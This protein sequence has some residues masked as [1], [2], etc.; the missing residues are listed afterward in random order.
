[1]DRISRVVIENIEPQVDQGRFLVKQ[2][3]GMP[4]VIQADIFADG[5][6]VI[7]ADLVWYIEGQEETK[8]VPLQFLSNDRW[9]AEFTCEQ[10]AIALFSIEAWIDPY[11]SWISDMEKKESQSATFTDIQVG[12]NLLKQLTKEKE[13]TLSSLFHTLSQTKSIEEAFAL[14]SQESVMQNV[15]SALSK[16]ALI[17][18]SN[19]L[20][21]QFVRKKALF[22][23]W[24]ELF[25]R[26]TSE[27]KGRHGTFQTCLKEL[28]RIAKMGFD[29]LYLPPIHPIGER[30]R[31]GKNNSLTATIQDPGSPWAIGSKDGG[32]DAIHP[33]LGTLTEFRQFVLEAEALGL[34]VAID[35]AFQCSPDHPYVQKHPEWFLWR[36]DGTAQCAENPPKK[37]ED[38][39]PFY[40]ETEDFENLWNELKRI[41][42]F[43][44]E[45]GVKIFR[46]DNPHTKPF[47]F[48]EWL[49]GEV[50]AHN[51]DVLFLAEA[52]TRPKV[53]E[54]LAKLGFDQSYTYFTWRQEKCEIIE[55]INLL[56]KIPLCHYFRPNFWTN[57]PDILPQ[58]LQYGGQAAFMARLVLAATLSSNYGIY[59][60]PFELCITEALE[61]KE[62]YADSEKYEIKCW[63]YTASTSLSS[64]IAHVN[65]IRKEHEAFQTTWNIEFL[66]C[67]NNN[68]LCYAKYPDFLV[69][70]NLDFHR[71][72]SGTVE[73][74]LEKFGI[75][76]GE[77]YLVHDLLSGD[78]YM[79]KGRQNYI[80]LNPH[81]C[82]AHILH[83]CTK[84]RKEQDFDYFL[85]SPQKPQT[86]VQ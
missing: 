75:E 24:Y 70:V 79:W 39:L 55:Y 63:D 76:E 59:G 10:P 45:Q 69:A 84:I 31:K 48:W 44:V 28:P 81:H 20:R 11:A 7:D 60:P 26:S 86:E 82:P 72:Q 62:E 47:A 40:F 61:D 25:P 73:V 6:Q 42:L 51:P 66:F 53:M 33:Q 16:Q 17:S 54:Y 68:L 80:E 1:M 23:T 30:F 21:V 19:W 65:A 18:K 43:W 46:V 14:L 56:A 67:P 38:I 34:E 9:Q 29:T 71:T 36:P 22:S 37:Y 8:R 83:I 78:R 13:K 41:T 58:H 85:P 15:R 64:F 74:P 5:H 49:I 27:E 52:F 57:T 77:T 4:C 50:K 2:I 35:L 32:H 12:K 3:V